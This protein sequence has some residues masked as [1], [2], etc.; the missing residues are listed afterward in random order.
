MP[1]SSNRILRG[2]DIK[3]WRTY[4]ARACQEL[5]RQAGPGSDPD[6]AGEHSSSSSPGEIERTLEEEKK[7]ILQKACQEAEKIYQDT[8]RQAR[9]EAEAI[10]E[11]A[12]NE[13][14]EKA[15]QKGES[16]AQK[17]REE[18][19][20]ILK[21]AHQKREEIIS[22]AEPEILRISVKLA[23][24]LLNCQLELNPRVILN[25]I[26]RSLEALPSGKEVVLKVNPEAEAFCREHLESLRGLLKNGASLQIEAD[27]EVPA[28][29]CLV[30]SEDAEVESSM[31]RELSV[32]GRRLIDISARQDT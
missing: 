26:S 15:V 1:S 9:E 6:S 11:K 10:K 29:S 24:K 27:Q 17:L 19:E 12:W 18:A 31:F 32:L 8:I 28:G 5:E 20:T 4:Q 14:Y 21:D 23:E 30:E 13:A 2:L 7:D 3:G 25:V 22:A 16:E